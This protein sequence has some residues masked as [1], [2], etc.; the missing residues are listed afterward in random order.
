MKFLAIFF[1]DK[2]DY[3]EKKSLREEYLEKFLR[4]TYS[5]N[6]L[7][8]FLIEETKQNTIP[9]VGCSALGVNLVM[10]ICHLWYQYNHGSRKEVS[11]QFVLVCNF[12]KGFHE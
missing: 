7:E 12:G 1:F 11:P 5:R 4:G 3:L 10:V 6:F 2:Y 9:F 8:K